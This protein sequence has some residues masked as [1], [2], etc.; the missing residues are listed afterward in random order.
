MRG[1]LSALLTLNKAEIN[2][3]AA[4][5]NKGKTVIFDDYQADTH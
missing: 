4:L 5:F 2:F 3:L 1:A